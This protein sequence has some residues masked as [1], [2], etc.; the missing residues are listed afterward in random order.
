M[1]VLRKIEPACVLP[2]SPRKNKNALCVDQT[3]WHGGVKQRATTAATSRRLRV[4][5]HLDGAAAMPRFP[6]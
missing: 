6:V 2:S 4:V 1:T 5:H 3:T